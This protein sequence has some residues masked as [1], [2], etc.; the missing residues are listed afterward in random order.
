M[1][2]DYILFDAG[3]RDQFAQFAADRSIPFTMRPDG[4]EG[5]VVALPDDLAD[6]IEEAVETEYERLMDA[7]R[8]LAEADD[9]ERARNL[10]GVTI[11]LADGRSS[12]V[13]LP[14]A[15]ARR[16]LQHFST[17]EIHALV[18]AVAHSVQHPVE[19][20]LCRTG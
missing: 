17:Q 19:G 10:L 1:T 20:P 14:G 15:I 8:T 18:S 11:T 6:D 12:V 9:G 4:I 5:Y 13:R 2:N 16:L 3:L 7:Q